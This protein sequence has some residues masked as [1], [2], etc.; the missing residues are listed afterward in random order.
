MNFYSYGNIKLINYKR[1]FV[2]F[3]IFLH[4][5]FFVSWIGL[6]FIPRSIWPDRV[7][8]HFWYVV[9]IIGL[10]L[11]WGGFLRVKY[12]K[13]NLFVCPLTTM[14]QYFR[15]YS[16]DDERNNKYLFVKEILLKFNI[17]N[18]KEVQIIAACISILIISYQY[19]IL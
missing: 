4:I 2:K 8:Y 6:F 14:T 16:I 1:L 3:L 11:I 19:F 18:A 12:G 9:G 5:I 17:K 7:F 15:G 10:N 13:G